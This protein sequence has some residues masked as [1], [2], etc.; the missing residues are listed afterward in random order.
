MA[1]TDQDSV[2]SVMSDSGAQSDPSLPPIPKKIKLAAAKAR[3]PSSSPDYGSGSD[4]N[5]D[6]SV[7]PS[8]V[9]ASNQPPSSPDK[10]ANA[11]AGAGADG[12]NNSGAGGSV[13]PA[14]KR[15]FGPPD[16]TKVSNAPSPDATSPLDQ[17]LDRSG[18][19][20]VATSVPTSGRAPNLNALGNSAAVDKSG[21]PVNPEQSGF[22]AFLGKVG[23]V[24]GI[25]SPNLPTSNGAVPSRADFNAVQKSRL[26][27]TLQAVGAVGGAMAAAG[28]TP[29]QQELAEKRAEF[30][31][32]MAMKGRML[33]NEMRYRDAMIGEKYAGLANA[34]DVAK[35]RTQPQLQKNQITARQHGQ[36][37]NP[38]GSV[39]PMTEDEILSDPLLSTNRELSMAAI[40][41]KIAAAEL[42]DAH[43]DVLM[44]PDNPT[45][46]QKER[47]IQSRLAIAKANLGARLQGLQMEGQRNMYDYGVDTMSG[48]TL[49][50]ENAA[51]GMLTDTAGNPIPNKSATNV[52]PTTMARNRSEQSDAISNASTMLTKEIDQNR[53]Y[54]GQMQGTLEMV[55]F[56]LR[57]PDPQFAQIKAA[58]LTYAA[59]QPGAHGM[60]SNEMV[61]EWAKTLPPNLDP[62]ALIAAIN[63]NAKM[64]EGSVGAAGRVHTV[65]PRAPAPTPPK[66]PVHAAAEK[67]RVRKYNAQ[68]GQLE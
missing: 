42:A 37:I 49:T 48:Q 33:E 61:E 26:S 21:N 55:E 43:R 29:T 36:I 44:N 47:E 66:T 3:I 4:P 38:D 64:L 23:R 67:T 63:E 65:P 35:L 40:Q 24:I 17:P 52:R 19:E 27:R 54:L 46:Q 39:R 1:L 25:A 28:G 16:V 22:R 11:V 57:N 53:Q 12:N 13:A 15:P 5:P 45:Y 2:Y 59:L 50:P 14:P 10:S 56:A 32:E 31:P 60:R 51:P 41:S 9:I 34:Q 7:D 68:T 62:D 18:I 20:T 58:L 30:G 8:R 6:P